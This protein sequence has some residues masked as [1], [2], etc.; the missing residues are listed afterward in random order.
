PSLPARS[1]KD[2]IQLAGARPG[3]IA[4]ATGGSPTQLAAELFKKNA[5]IDVV[6]VPYKGNAPAVTATLSGETSL[7]FGGI[8]Q[9]VPQVKA[10]RLRALGVAGAQRSGVLPEVPTIAESGLPGFEASGWYGL[11][12]PGTTPRGVVERLNAEVVRILRLPDVSQ[13]LRGEAFEIP[14]E[15]PDQFAAVI[16]AELAKWAPIVKETGIRPE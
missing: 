16:H 12:A 13:R 15:T 14:A 8:A 1:A 4:W 3:E 6:I 9:S 2:L 11:L 10:G 7:V 5:R